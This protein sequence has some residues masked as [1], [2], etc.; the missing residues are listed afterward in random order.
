MTVPSRYRHADADEG[1]RGFA[2]NVARPRTPILFLSHTRSY[3]SCPVPILNSSPRSTATASCGSTTVRRW[4]SSRCGTRSRSRTGKLLHGR[5]TLDKLLHNKLVL[6]DGVLL[7]P[8]TRDDR[9][10]RA[11]GRRAQHHRVGSRQGGTRPGS[12]R[13]RGR[14]TTTPGVRRPT[15]VLTRA[16][17]TSSPF[18]PSAGHRHQRVPLRAR[19][20]VG[21]RPDRLSPEYEVGD[22]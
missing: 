12:A 14:A 11:R 13:P 4:T 1:A 5:Y 19:G 22:R 10:P 15:S 18:R 6:D 21:A 16:R 3:S 7:A 20:L 8:R 17:R 2:A 9:H